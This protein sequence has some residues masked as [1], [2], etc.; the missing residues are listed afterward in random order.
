MGI[1]ESTLAYRDAVKAIN[2]ISA[3]PR[4]MVA[5]QDLT[6]LKALIDLE[7]A[8]LPADKPDYTE[9]ENNHAKP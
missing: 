6:A 3:N 1:I 8:K 9:E 2:A 4:P 7:L 5:R